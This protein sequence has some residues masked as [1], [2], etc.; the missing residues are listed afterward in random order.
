MKEPAERLLD[1][2]AEKVI[3]ANDLSRIELGKE[4]G[5]LRWTG[6]KESYAILEKHAQLV[7]FTP[8]GKPGLYYVDIPSMQHGRFSEGSCFSVEY[9]PGV[10]KPMYSGEVTLPMVR[11]WFKE[12]L[13]LLLDD[14]LMD[15]PELIENP[16]PKKEAVHADIQN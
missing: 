9:V 8:R 16:M 10:S 14:V 6:W 12:A 1:L 4:I 2:I 15:S 13:M 7:L 11:E 3:T 5:V